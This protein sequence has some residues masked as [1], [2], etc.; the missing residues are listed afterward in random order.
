MLFKKNTKSIFK[1]LEL[2][3]FSNKFNLKNVFLFPNLQK[4]SFSFSVEKSLKTVEENKTLKN[5]EK[6][7]CSL[8]FLFLNS[9]LLKF[10]KNVTAKNKLNADTDTII[11]KALIFDNQK[12]L[13]FLS[14]LFLENKQENFLNISNYTLKKKDFFYVKTIILPLS[15]FYDLFTVL[16][17]L[18]VD[19]S[20]IKIQTKTQFWFKTKSKEF[21]EYLPLFFIKQ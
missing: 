17:F 12:Q 4:I 20:V 7:F 5:I 16:N 8:Y 9:P 19:L 11:L 13:D 1:K 3:D 10:K 21:I 6:I 18:Q 14:S 2:I 15:F